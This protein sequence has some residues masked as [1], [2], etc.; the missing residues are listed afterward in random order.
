MEQNNSWFAGIDR[1]RR[2]WLGA[3][4]ALGGLTAL[5]R[6]RAAGQES[7]R[8]PGDEPGHRLVYQ[9]NRID[10]DYQQHVIHSIGAVLRQYPD[11]VKLAVVCFGPGINLLAKSPRQPVAEEIRQHVASLAGYG[12]EFHACNVTL[13]SLGWSEKEL[14]PFAK[15]VPSGAADLMELQE[16][17]FAYVSW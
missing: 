8:F 7:P 16:K 2:R 15:V 17:R 11:E 12:V 9:F 4:V 14:V 5:G 3:L 13:Q 10:P 1:A 6:A